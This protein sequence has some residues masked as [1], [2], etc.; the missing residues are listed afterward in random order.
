M[1]NS[2]ICFKDKN[3]GMGVSMSIPIGCECNLAEGG[4]RRSEGNPWQVIC[5][6]SAAAVMLWASIMFLV[7]WYFS[8]IC[9]Q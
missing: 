8:E 9:L 7:F 4:T 3:L 1:E 6:V 2:L 5:T